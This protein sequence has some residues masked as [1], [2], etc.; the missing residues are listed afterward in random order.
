MG[1]EKDP[2]HF[3]HA[4]PPKMGEKNLETLVKFTAQGLRLTKRLRP[5]HRTTE[6]FSSPTIYHHIIKV[7]FTAIPFAWYILSFYQ[8]KKKITKHAKRQKHNLK[9]KSIR[10]RY[11]RML[12]LSDQEFKTT[13]VNILKALVKQNRH[14]F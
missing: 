14:S 9:F 1:K 10:T 12:E 4:V 6:C 5:N 13:M 8:E 11:S 7:L 2:A 3:S